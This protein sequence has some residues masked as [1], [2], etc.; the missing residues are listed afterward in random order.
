MT[1]QSVI[2]DSELKNESSSLLDHIMSQ[3]RLQPED[4]GYDIAKQGISAFIANLLESGQEDV[5]VNKLLVDR[6]IVELDKKMSAQMDAILHS[7]EF[8]NMESSWRS[9]KLLVDRTDFRE[10]IKITI[11]H[12]TKRRAIRRF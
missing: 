12:A 3:A 4:E 6:M 7:D 1:V 11:L 9:L 2:H 10:N 5:P 8:Q